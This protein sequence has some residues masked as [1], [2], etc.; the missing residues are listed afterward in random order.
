MVEV[1]R[2]Y[3]VSLNGVG[4]TFTLAKSHV[5]CEGAL[6]PPYPF[7]HQVETESSAELLR[8][9]GLLYTVYLVI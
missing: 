3:K 8:Q 5:N 2:D 7:E 6:F 1:G 9:W 4:A